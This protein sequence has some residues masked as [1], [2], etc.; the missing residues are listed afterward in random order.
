MQASDGRAGLGLD[1]V[2]WS[3]GQKSESR[4]H[5]PRVLPCVVLL[6]GLLA[7]SPAV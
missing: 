1:A 3:Q 5:A 7:N 4:R 6:L 2:F